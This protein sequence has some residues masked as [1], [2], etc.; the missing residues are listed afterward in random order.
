[1]N[2]NSYKKNFGLKVKH[3][4]L[5]RNLTQAAF[6]EIVNLSENYISLIENGHKNVSLKTLY[7]FSQALEVDSSKFF[8]FD[9]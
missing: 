9:E 6:G 5:L 4:R 3:Y 8:T 1:M 2:F 7:K